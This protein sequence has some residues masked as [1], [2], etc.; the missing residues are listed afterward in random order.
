[1]DTL[2][3]LKIKIEE[4]ESNHVKIEHDNVLPSQVKQ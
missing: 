3:A 1:M 4:E 2:N